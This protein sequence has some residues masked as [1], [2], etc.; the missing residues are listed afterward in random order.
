MQHTM[1]S[2]RS[3][4]R[5]P[6]NLEDLLRLRTVEQDRIEC[7]AGWNPDAIVRTL[8]ALANDFENPR[9]SN[10]RYRITP[11]GRA[12]LEARNNNS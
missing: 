10:Q 11:A 7:K 5:L 1:Y 4:S 12:V 8:C 9:R 6:I 2:P 3:N